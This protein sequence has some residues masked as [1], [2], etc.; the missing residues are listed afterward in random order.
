MTQFA[1]VAALMLFL[2]LAFPLIPLLRRRA[3]SPVD[4]NAQRLKALDQALASGVIDQDE[5]AA[6]RA[7][8]AATPSAQPVGTSSRAATMAAIALAIC[9][10]AASVLM[11]RAVGEPAALDPARMAAA[12]AADAQHNMDMAQAIAGLRAKLEQSPDNP[13]GWALL[14]R[15]YQAAGQFAE[16]RDAL[17]H[18]Y[19]LVPENQDLAVEYAQAMALANEGRRI[20]GDSR[21]LIEDVLKIDP[22]HQRALWL[23]GIS[24]YQA[25]NY[26]GAITSW[27]RLLPN[28]P[29][30]SDIAMSV[31]AQIAEAQKLGGTLPM[32]E[33]TGAPDPSSTSTTIEAA[34]ATTPTAPETAGDGPRLTV[35]VALDPKLADKLDPQATLFVFARAANGPPMPL[36]IQR[37]SAASLPITVTLDESMGMVPN[38]K[39][40]M[41]PQV[42]IGA[43]ISKSGQAM[44]QSGDLQTLSAPIDVTHK[45]PIAIVIDSVVP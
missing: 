1:I 31:R 18:A 38:V 10:P 30:D 27:N 7:S 4:G 41:F 45:D 36:S 5:Y 40:S 3:G 9:L 8:L 37:L 23:F 12:P 6:K 21:K 24:D 43:R 42:I 29:A 39:L 33:T 35:K 19:D 22:D 2:A 13:E 20:E 14:G 16:S 28:L 11:Y 32:V 17:K 25:G 26:D 34:P 44:P 15:A